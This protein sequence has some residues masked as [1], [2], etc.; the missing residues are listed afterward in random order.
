MFKTKFLSKVEIKDAIKDTL[1]ARK[2]L[3][4]V[5]NQGFPRVTHPTMEVWKRGPEPGKSAHQSIALIEVNIVH[6]ILATNHH[7]GRFGIGKGTNPLNSRSPSRTSI[8]SSTR[9]RRRSGSIHTLANKSSSRRSNNS[10]S[11]G[12]TPRPRTQRGGGRSEPA[13]AAPGEPSSTVTLRRTDTKQEGVGRSLA[14]PT[15]RR[16]WNM[17]TRACGQRQ[18]PTE[19]PTHHS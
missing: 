7:K 2:E 14:A 12:K 18:T 10:L 11:K 13:K 1:P 5:D 19:Q 17:Q 6:N 4:A 3:N 9:K 15:P 8:T 16:G